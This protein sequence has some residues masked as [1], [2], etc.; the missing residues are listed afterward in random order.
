MNGRIFCAG[1]FHET[2][3]FL[4]ERTARRDFRRCG[5]GGAE[6]LALPGSPMEGAVRALAAEG[7]A[8]AEGPYWLA[9]PSG[10]VED[11]VLSAWQD[12]FR[13][14]WEASEA[15]TERVD[16]IFLVLHG[17]MC[18][19]TED[20]VEARAAEWI[21]SLSGAAEIPVFA[22]LDLHGNISPEFCRAV[23]GCV[24]YRENPHIDAVEAAGRAAAALARTVREGR[25][26]RT[27]WKGLGFIWP[28]SGTGTAGP[29]MSALESLAR[30]VEAEPGV[31]AAN[32]F[33]GYSYSDT[34]D[35]G[36]SFALSVDRGVSG[37]QAA[38]WLDHL[39]GAASEHREAGYPE[40]DP[41][42][43]VVEAVR[44]GPAR[45]VLVAEPSD[46]IGAGAPGDGTGL[47]RLFFE[48]GL[49]GA[50]AILD[51]P[52]SVRKLAGASPGEIR[53]LAI[54]GRG[55]RLDPGPLERDWKL[56][57][58]F[59]GAFAL[60]DPRSHLASMMGTAIDMGDCAVI[61]SAGVTVL[62]TSAKTPPF[63]LGQWRVA[64]IDPEAFRVIG[65]KA[66]VAYRRAYDPIASAHFTVDTPGPC[67][68]DLR[69]LPFQRVRRPVY[70]LDDEG[71]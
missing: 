36:P 34:R 21:R 58:L 7:F 32:V 57:R 5:F 61:R 18:T 27:F 12:L 59:R 20:D 66:A 33:A 40:A 52:A 16:G 14:A 6:A 46:N 56:V 4:E 30:E 25:A 15:S 64:G 60:E 10:T 69:G 17:A 13:E 39:S 44:R 35:C 65:V 24:A 54:G 55:S 3:S 51:D 70:P 71:S 42:E 62:L 41:I 31:I 45:P 29:P 68:L 1:I 37:E 11:G 47:L 26:A 50:G 22:V 23:N 53:R 19:E 8:A 63:D 67:R 9:M 2:H 49:E 28:P 38:A 48:H 43:R